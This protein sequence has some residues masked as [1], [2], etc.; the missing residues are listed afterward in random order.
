M[1]YN[2][3]LRKKVEIAF[4]FSGLRPADRYCIS[5]ESGVERQEDRILS[6]EGVKTF[7]RGGDQ[8]RE[9]S[10]GFACSTRRHFCAPPADGPPSFGGVESRRLHPNTAK[11]RDSC[12]TAM[13]SALN[14]R[15]SW[16]NVVDTSAT[17]ALAPAPAPIPARKRPC[18]HQAITRLFSLTLYVITLLRYYTEE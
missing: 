8:V 5:I 7:A 6:K 9:R 16:Y 15:G 13:D 10:L 4:F 18:K 12:R 3:N 2:Y 1:G 17:A 14:G 11:P